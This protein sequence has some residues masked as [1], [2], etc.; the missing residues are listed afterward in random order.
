MKSE[1]LCSFSNR[2]LEG[3]KGLNILVGGE[4]FGAYVA[5]GGQVGLHGHSV[6]HHQLGSD[7]AEQVQCSDAGHE[8]I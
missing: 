2:P 5:L 6:F 4:E 1:K 8:A 3:V 7:F